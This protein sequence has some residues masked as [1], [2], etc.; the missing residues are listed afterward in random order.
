MND[1]RGILNPAAE[2]ERFQLMRREPGAA[3]SS[4][5]E[6]YWSVRW[7]L[8]PGES[9]LTETLP[10]PSV[11]LVFEVGRSAVNGV[12]TKRW[13]RSLS[14]AGRVFGVK[15]VPGAFSAFFNRPIH[16]LT[17]RVLPVAEVFGA[18]GSQLESEL[19]AR[20]ADAERVRVFEAFLS[21]RLPAPDAERERVRAVVTLALATPS[22]RRVDELASGAGLPTRSLQRLFRRYL[23]VTPKW[24]LCR[25]RIQEAAE[26]VASGEAI[27]WAA[28]AADLGYFDQAH[29]ATDFKAQVG[30]TP[31]EYAAFA[32][33]HGK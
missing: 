7:A 21:A 2:G 1:S 27:D 14:G 8:G 33:S 5:V 4:V 13:S 23:G 26:R 17:D 25:F 18:A 28:L 29:F 24:L 19:L 22:L 10:F 3:V 15:F 32:Q 12:C 6:R 9:Y 16:Q 11:N 20:E 31:S 30:K